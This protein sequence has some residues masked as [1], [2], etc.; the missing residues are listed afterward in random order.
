MVSKGDELPQIVLDAKVQ[1]IL[2]WKSVIVLVDQNI[3]RY[4]QEIFAAIESE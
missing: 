1:S 3:R 4:S 2:K